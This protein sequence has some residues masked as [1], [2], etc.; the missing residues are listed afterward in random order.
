MAVGVP[1]VATPVGGSAEIGEEGTTHL[2]ATTNEEWRRALDD[3]LTNADRRL[4]MGAAGRSHVIEH[5]GLEAQAEKLADAL[6][7]AANTK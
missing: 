7:E 6:R 2:F 4:Q 3:L 1:Y 5:Y